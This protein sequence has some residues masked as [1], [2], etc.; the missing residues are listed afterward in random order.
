MSAGDG[1][2]LV[3]FSA[4][5]RP[6]TFELD[7]VLEEGLVCCFVFG[8]GISDPVPIDGMD[9]LTHTLVGLL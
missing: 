3:V 7:R 4:L 6:V 2:I 5:G 1:A 9:K 8:E